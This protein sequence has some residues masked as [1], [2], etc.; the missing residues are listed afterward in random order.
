MDSKVAAGERGTVGKE[1]RRF[2]TVLPDE[3]AAL[4]IGF[5]TGVY[6]WW[7]WFSGWATYDPDWRVKADPF[8][9][10]FRGSHPFPDFNGDPAWSVSLMGGLLSELGF[11]L[12]VTA[13]LYVG[14]TIKKT[15]MRRRAAGLWVAALLTVSLLCVASEKGLPFLSIPVLVAGT[16]L[17]V[18]VSFSEFDQGPFSDVLEG[19]S[20]VPFFCGLAS[21]VS[22]T[23]YP[24]YF[25]CFR[26]PGEA[27]A[28]PIPALLAVLFTSL[29]YAVPVGIQILRWKR[30]GLPRDSLRDYTRQALLLPSVVFGLSSTAMIGF[31][32]LHPDY[33]R[34]GN[35]V[36]INLFF[37]IQTSC[38]SMLIVLFVFRINGFERGIRQAVSLPDKN[39]RST[40]DAAGSP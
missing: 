34:H 24:Y 22:V 38:V 6:V 23:V 33:H 2:G 39:R 21:L 12:I 10:L 16:I 37:Y 13:F 20:T 26:P 4:L 8:T 28:N 25:N 36:W 18:F 3:V 35:A 14:R 27:A 32:F 9:R 17:A 11:V 31:T 15:R 29:I 7:A 5:F 1:F 19:F 40:P 30:F